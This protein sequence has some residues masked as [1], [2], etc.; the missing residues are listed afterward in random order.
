M[1]VPFGK[2]A[3]FLGVGVECEGRGGVQ[4]TPDPQEVVKF[5]GVSSRGGVPKQ[6][7]RWGGEG[8]ALK[9]PGGACC[10]SKV[11]R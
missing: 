1:P 7:L 2:L 9:T 10:R 6:D 3:K 4:T 11:P 5:H 8:V